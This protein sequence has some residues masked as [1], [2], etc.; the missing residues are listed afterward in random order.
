M[1]P[2]KTRTSELAS[3]RRVAYSRDLYI[4]LY[5]SVLTSLI[6]DNAEVKAVTEDEAEELAT[7]AARI[8]EAALGKIEARFPG[9]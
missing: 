5:T 2:S 1:P 7:S 4:D 6:S 9:L 8:A 3:K